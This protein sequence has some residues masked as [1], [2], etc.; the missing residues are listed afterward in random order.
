MESQFITKVHNYWTLS[1][2]PFLSVCIALPRYNADVQMLKKQLRLTIKASTDGGDIQA[3]I[4]RVRG[5]E[6]DHDRPC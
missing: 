1:K 2:H 3:V 6:G 4:D 5:S